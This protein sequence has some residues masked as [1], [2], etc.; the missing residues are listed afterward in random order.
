MTVIEELEK[1]APVYLAKLQ[2]APQT[3][4]GSHPQQSSFSLGEQL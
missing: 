2:L 4:P 1:Q 3:Q